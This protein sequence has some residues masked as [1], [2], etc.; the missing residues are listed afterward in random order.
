MYRARRLFLFVFGFQGAVSHLIQCRR[1]RF[2]SVS[3]ERF[4]YTNAQCNIQTSNNLY[5]LF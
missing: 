5:H 3:L 1:F 4:N 2:N